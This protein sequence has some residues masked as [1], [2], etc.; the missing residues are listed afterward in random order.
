MHTKQFLPVSQEEA[1]AFISDPSNLKHITPES[2]GFEITS[3]GLPEKMYP[4]MII[5]YSVKPLLGIKTT[6]VTEIT[7]VRERQYF[8]DEQRVGP[9]T[10]WH[11][12]HHLEPAEG[13]VVM[14]DIVT[15]KPPLGVLG[16]MANKLIIRRK[17]RQ[18]FRYRE[19][20]LERIFPAK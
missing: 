9:Y 7:H 14:R 10:I 4:G 6:W 11:H 1:W 13:G 3:E 20:A 15:Y 2:M 18:I 17:L 12:E 16:S 5:T 8:V 19:K